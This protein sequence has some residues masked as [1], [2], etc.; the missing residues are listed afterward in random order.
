MFGKL[1]KQKSRSPVEEM[2]QFYLNQFLNNTKIPPQGNNSMSSFGQTMGPNP[3]LGPQFQNQM[4]TPMSQGGFNPM[5]NNNFN[6]SQFPMM[7][8]PNPQQF[9]T[10]N[11]NQMPNPFSMNEYMPPNFIP[12]NNN[13]NFNPSSMPMMTPSNNPSS[14]LNNPLATNQMVSHYQSNTPYPM[15]NQMDSHSFQSMSNLAYSTQQNFNPSLI[16]QSTQPTIGAEPTF[17]DFSFTQPPQQSL[18]DL[19]PSLDDLTESNLLSNPYFRPSHKPTNELVLENNSKSPH[20]NTTISP[21]T[22]VPTSPPPSQNQAFQPINDPTDLP[23][24]QRKVDN[25]NIRLRKIESYLGFRP[26]TTI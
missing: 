16:N 13:Q 14:M 3:S 15:N 23:E 18:P 9:S 19:T 21:N 5:M 8:T 10:M 22:S 1:K 4:G 7:N 24:L 25:I 11:Q 26:E 17:N 2:E 12:N 20:A 6:N